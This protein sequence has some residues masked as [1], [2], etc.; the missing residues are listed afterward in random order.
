MSCIP[1][2]R[3]KGKCGSQYSSYRNFR[4]MLTKLYNNATDDAK[5]QE[6]KDAIRQIDIYISQ[7]STRCTT[8]LEF[9]LIRDY[10]NNEYK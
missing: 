8:D 7:I 1:C 3:K 9:N 2:S 6:Y 10:V 4:K 5:K